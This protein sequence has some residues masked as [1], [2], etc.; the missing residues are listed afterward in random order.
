[1]PAER[2]LEMD[3]GGALRMKGMGCAGIAISGR[4]PIGKP[5]EG[6]EFK[7]TI[8]ALAQVW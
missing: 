6:M 1:M 8:Q 7:L 2:G 4:P 3:L 5:K